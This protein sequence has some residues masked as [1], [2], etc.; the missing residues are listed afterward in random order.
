M[1]IH[2]AVVIGLAFFATPLAGGESSDLPVHFSPDLSNAKGDN[3][4]FL[5]GMLNEY[6]GR[7]FVEKSDLVE[8]FYCGEDCEAHVFL[9]YLKRVAA[10]QGLDASVDVRMRQACLTGLHSRMLTEFIDSFYEYQYS[11]GG[12]LIGEDGIRRRAGSA[13][14][15]AEA[16]ARAKERHKLAFLVGAFYRYGRDG[17]F[18]YANSSERVKLVMALLTEVG[19]ENVR[20]ESRPGIPSQNTVRFDADEKLRDLI[21]QGAADWAVSAAESLMGTPDEDEV[22]VYKGALK[23]AIEGA[24]D[25]CA[26]PTPVV[27]YA[28]NFIDMR[29]R[30]T[31]IP[32]LTPRFA[33]ALDDYNRNRS[34][35]V[36]LRSLASDE[37]RVER[38]PQEWPE[39]CSA[40]IL[41]AGFDQTRTSAVVLF[42]YVCPQPTKCIRTVAVLLTKHDAEWRAESYVLREKTRRWGEWRRD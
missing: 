5:L 16:F 36:S 39:L 6:A 17:G 19:C 30:D 28:S 8:S 27:I 3:V 18:V 38:R 41:R 13:S 7:N 23:A 35:V 29:K 12:R 40:W 11:S 26:M 1:R 14:L 33:D 21:T 42:T 15:S 9:A 25:G 10:E 22:A 4:F 31:S 37:I 32:G 20:F 2:I 24:F 34:D